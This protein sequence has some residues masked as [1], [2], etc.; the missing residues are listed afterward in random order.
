MKKLTMAVLAMLALGATD[1]AAQT[2]GSASVT[3]PTVLVVSNVT[4]LNIAETDFNM[5]DFAS[6]N[7]AQATGSVTIDTR[8]NITHAVDV[9]GADLLLG[10][11]ALALEVQASDGTWATLSGTAVKT[12]DN[13]V[14]GPQTG[15]I[16]N[17]RATADVTQHAPGTYTGTITYTV[18]ANY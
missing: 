12:L 17:F 8:S 13:L 15:N 3:I 9:S 10:T 7:T 4:D 18:V 16:I 2:N 11:D 1:V 14:R 5:A 6:S